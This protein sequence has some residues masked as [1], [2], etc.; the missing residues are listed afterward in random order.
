VDNF[1]EKRPPDAAKAPTVRHPV[2][3]ALFLMVLNHKEIKGLA[4][5]TWR[6]GAP[7]AVA[8]TFAHHVDTSAPF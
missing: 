4:R 2:G 3:A 1:V 8:A 6:G 5:K 7:V